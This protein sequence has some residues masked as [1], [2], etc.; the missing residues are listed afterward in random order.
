MGHQITSFW[1]FIFK[2]SF[3]SILWRILNPFA[4]N[5]FLL[6]REGGWIRLIVAMTLNFLT[7]RFAWP[8]TVTEKYILW[9]VFWRMEHLNVVCALWEF[10]NN[11][12]C[13]H[14]CFS[15]ITRHLKITFESNK[16]ICVIYL[17]VC[18]LTSKNMTHVGNSVSHCCLPFLCSKFLEFIPCTNLIISWPYAFALAVSSVWNL[19]LKHGQILLVLKDHIYLKN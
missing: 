14:S 10:D 13:C 8:F 1:N 17:Y 15:F 12:V 9:F 7:W 18:F 16:N 19:P 6:V 4:L 5:S 3:V 11:V 2:Y